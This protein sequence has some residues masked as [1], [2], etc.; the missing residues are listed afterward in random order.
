MPI[1][2]ESP[3]MDVHMFCKIVHILKLN[4]IEITAVNVFLRVDIC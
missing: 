4:T 3:D 1:A 2:V